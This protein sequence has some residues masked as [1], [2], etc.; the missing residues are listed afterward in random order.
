MI[1]IILFLTLIGLPILYLFFLVVYGFLFYRKSEEENYKNFNYAWLNHV[2]IG[3]HHWQHWVLITDEKD[4]IKFEI[5]DKYL[6]EM[7]CDWIG[8]G[9][10]QKNGI[11]TK[12][13]Y[14]YHKDKMSIHPESRK[15]LEK[16]INKL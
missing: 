11:D 13:W 12:E 4:L 6:K 1:L 15:K 7:L 2:S 9:K 16:M 14:S 8:A 10:S 3:K 5:P